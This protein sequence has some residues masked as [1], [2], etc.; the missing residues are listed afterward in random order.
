MSFDYTGVARIAQSTIKKFGGKAELFR[1]PAKNEEPVSVAKTST[2]IS[3][4]TQLAQQG[5]SAGASTNTTSDV[6]ALV[7]GLLKVVPKT[8]D[9]FKVGDRTY[10]VNRVEVINPTG[11]MN[12]L[13][14]LGLE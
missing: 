4:W 6:A 12:L 13:Y 2:V 3:T 7:T 10:N 14:I 9:H 1:R 11:T 5:F 8:G